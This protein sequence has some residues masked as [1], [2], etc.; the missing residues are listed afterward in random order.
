[1]MTGLSTQRNVPMVGECGVIKGHNATGGL[2]SPFS[3]FILQ[4]S[5]GPRMP[6]G[7]NFPV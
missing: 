1:M 3:H 7:R 4:R 6:E 2:L 5:D